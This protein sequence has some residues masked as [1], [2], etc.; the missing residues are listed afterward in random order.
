VQ[1]NYTFTVIAVEYFTKWIEAKPLTN[2]SSA[3]IKKFFW[4]DIICRYGVP[5]HI[6]VDNAKYFDNAMFKEFCQ[7]INMKVAFALVH[8]PQLNG[9]VEKENYLIFQAMKK[10]FKGEKK[11][12]WAE[13]MQIIVWSHNTTVY[14]AT[15]FTPF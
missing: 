2:V 13:V 4:R 8:L 10:T 11:G 12:K 7:Q 6:T 1:H 5:R 3:T 9:A 15:N 14:R